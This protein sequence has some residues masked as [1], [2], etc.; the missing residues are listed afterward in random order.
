M[1]LI[2]LIAM[3]AIEVANSYWGGDSRSF[4]GE[5]RWSV[6]VTSMQMT[7]G[8]A[9]GFARFFLDNCLNYI[10]KGSNTE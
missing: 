3:I 1:A 4:T 9:I 7:T 6:F 10:K 8:V 2:F 5:D